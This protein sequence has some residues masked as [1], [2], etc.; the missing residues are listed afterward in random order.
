MTI[1]IHDLGLALTAYFVLAILQVIALPFIFLLGKKFTYIVDSFWAFGRFVTLLSL[2]FLIWILA[3]LGLPVYTAL[4][5][6]LF[7]FLFA[8][9]S[10][11]INQKIGLKSWKFFWQKNKKI[12]LIEEI[13][14]LLTYLFILIMRSFQPEILSL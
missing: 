11:R 5:I 12:I 3:H 9:L 8:L 2:S 13:I 14:F 6:Y 10:F 7:L 1:L 4:M